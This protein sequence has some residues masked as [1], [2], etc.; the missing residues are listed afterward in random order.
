VVLLVN[1]GTS[2]ELFQAE[3]HASTPTL[4]AQRS[5]TSSGAPG[6]E[7]VSHV[8]VPRWSRQILGP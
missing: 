1:T 6:G 2:L 5:T 3:R 7:Q 4:K 8:Q